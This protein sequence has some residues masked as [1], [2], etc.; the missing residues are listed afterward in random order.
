VRLALG[1]TAGEVR[2]LVLGRALGLAAFALLVGVPAALALGRLMASAL[3]GV[4]RVD[5]ASLAA[6]SGGLLA[7]ALLA[8]L[9]PA[10]RAAALDPV[11]VLR[12][13]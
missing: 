8:G 13:E 10:L 5:A 9:V 7:T 12:S 2:R 1:A 11:A 4:V 3:F 6:F